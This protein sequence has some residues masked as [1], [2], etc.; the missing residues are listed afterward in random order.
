VGPGIYTIWRG[1]Q[2]LYVGIA[3][4]PAIRGAVS[5]TSKG[6]HGR[7]ESH[8]S[9]RRSSDQFCIYVCDRLVLPTIQNQLA[10]VANGSLSL[11]LLTRAFVH[12]QLSYRFVAT[13]DYAQAMRLEGSIKRSGLPQAGRPL[14]NPGAMPD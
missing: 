13:I 1:T 3:G 8:A 7:L 14:L 4:R 6:L 10:E 5:G 9:G 2:F 11:D 12:E